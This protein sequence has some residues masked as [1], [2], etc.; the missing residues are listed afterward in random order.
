MD[1]GARG[2]QSLALHGQRLIMEV[3]S[4]VDPAT[5]QPQGT[6]AWPSQISNKQGRRSRQRAPPLEPRTWSV[7]SAGFVR[8][9]LQTRC[10]LRT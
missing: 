5:L 4:S 8:A 1:S 3:N 6:P 9:C 7:L 10:N 2:P